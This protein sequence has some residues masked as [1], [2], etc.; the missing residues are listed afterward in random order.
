MTAR[1]RSGAGLPDFQTK[2]PNLG[3]FWR[4]LQRKILVYFMAIGPVLR[5]LG[6]LCGHLIYLWLFGI[7][8][9]FGML[10]Q[11]KSGN[12]L[13][14]C[15][16]SSLLTTIAVKAGAMQ[17]SVQMYACSKLVRLVKRKQMSQR[18]RPMYRSYAKFVHRHFV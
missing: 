9:S 1:S 15:E 17:L 12:P 2:N 8:S 5:P 18:T 3:K 7:F 10:Y 16:S 4:D 13:W 11:E 6:I 14:C